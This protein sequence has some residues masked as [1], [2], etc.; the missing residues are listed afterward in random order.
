MQMNGEPLPQVMTESRGE[1]GKL[2]QTFDIT[3]NKQLMSTSGSA[4]TTSSDD[5]KTKSSNYGPFF[6]EYSMM[7]E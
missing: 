7:A 2:V 6:M 3:A 1:G 5:N 4:Q